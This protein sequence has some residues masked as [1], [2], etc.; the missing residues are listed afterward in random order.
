MMSVISTLLNGSKLSL[1]LFLLLVLVCENHLMSD[2]MYI[3]TL[4]CVPA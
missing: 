3:Y 2:N 4:L 1:Q